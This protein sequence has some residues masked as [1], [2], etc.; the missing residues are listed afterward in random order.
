MR[1]TLNILYTI[2]FLGALGSCNQN[3]KDTDRTEDHKTEETMEKS[4]TLKLLVGTYTNT[5]SKGIYMV[6]FDPITGALDNKRLVAQA[7]NPSYLWISKDGSRVFAVNETDP[8]TVSSF[9]WNPDGTAL[10]PIDKKLS[11]GVHPCFLELNPDG[12]LLAVAN[13]SS[14]TVA[15]FRVGANGKLE[16]APQV[17][18]HQG[19]GPVLPNQESAHAHYALFGTGQK[20]LYAVD[21]GMDKVLSYPLTGNGEM[22]QQQ[23][24]LALNPGD[25]PRHLV[26]HPTKELVF[27][28]TELS[29]TVVS[30]KVDPQ[31]GIFAKLDQQST[32]PT[33][34]TG[35]NACADIHISANGKFVYASNRGHNSIAVFAVK[36]DG[37]LELI[38]TSVTEGDWPR[39]FSLSPDGN[40][41]LVANQNSN[42]ITVFKVD[43]TTGLLTYT[44]KQIQVPMPVC[45]AF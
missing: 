3:K 20:F 7:E 1:A 29:S 31:T 10:I 22:G 21:L 44:G 12:D 32:L 41:L 34:Y 14:G 40:F 18:Q 33:D 8:G 27:I 43:P 2:I 39:N 42:N 28:I 13:Y 5:D 17:R 36:D 19:S 15:V 24:A 4:E 26:F 35:D 6:D 30:A 45:L 25:G 9:Q 11:A 37:K 16:A 38:G 23:T